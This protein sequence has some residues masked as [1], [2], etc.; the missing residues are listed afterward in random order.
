MIR[1][2]NKVLLNNGIDIDLISYVIEIN[3]MCPEPVEEHLLQ[4]LLEIMSSQYIHYSIL[5]EYNALQR[6][7][8]HS[9]HFIDPQTF[10]SIIEINNPSLFPVNE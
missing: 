2:Y 10:R 6:K 5:F 1:Q 4:D 9:N 8:Y 3:K 7:E